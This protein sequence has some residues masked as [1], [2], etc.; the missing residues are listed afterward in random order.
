MDQSYI[1]RNNISR[2]RLRNVVSA[3]SEATFPVFVHGNWTV[4]AT[5]AHLAAE[6]RRIQGWLEEWDRQGVR[7]VAALREWEQWAIRTYGE[8]DNDERLAQWLAADPEAT[9]RDVIA[10]AE[11]IDAK[12]ET[13]SPVL[14]EAL[15]NTTPFWGS[16]RQWAL[17]R[18]IHRHEHL[19][20]IERAVTAK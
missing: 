18:S 17:D 9:V 14:A 11:S 20:A 13:L 7:E 15:L 19:D 6:D 16:R 4:R 8:N 3:L 12:I 2:E 10:A 5:L 1:T